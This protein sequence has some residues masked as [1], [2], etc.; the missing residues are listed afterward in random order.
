MKSSA[1]VVRLPR[2]VRG[3][4]IVREIEAFGFREEAAECEPACPSA[5]AD[6]AANERP[7]AAEEMARQFAAARE[8]AKQEGRAEGLARGR[9][10]GLD[11]AREPAKLLEKVMRRVTEERETLLAKA[12]RDV[13][14]LAIAVAARIVR[15]E[16]EVDRDLV[17]RVIGD[18]LRHA[19]PLEEVVVRVNPTDYARIK[20]VPGLEASLGEIRHLV[21]VEDRR[22]TTGGCLIETTSGAIDARVETQ[23]A[24][25]ERALARAQGG[26]AI[27]ADAS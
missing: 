9:E 5:A 25:I 7:T 6:S 2:A 22:V 10:E 19:S 27:A 11:T 23:L 20:S 24:E 17:T 13:L 26:P 18:A 4:S 14:D 15:R 12:E 8:E 3:L 16:V 1:N 21:L